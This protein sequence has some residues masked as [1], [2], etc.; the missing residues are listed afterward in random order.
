MK[1]EKVREDIWRGVEGMWELDVTGPISF[2]EEEGQPVESW[3]W[4]LYVRLPAH[5]EVVLADDS[6]R[7]GLDLRSYE[8]ALRSGERR[9]HELREKAGAVC[10]EGEVEEGWIAVDVKDGRFA[11]WL[12]TLPKGGIGEPRDF[13]V[14][15][16][17]RL[18]FRATAYKR[19]GDK[20]VI[21][22]TR[23]VVTLGMNAT[24]LLPALRFVG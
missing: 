8:Q 2:W 19:E 14:N 10:R 5:E 4:D 24:V 7:S 12:C 16:S 23:G 1:M 18:A 11:M 3:R 20:F 9:L 21:Q 6:E 22:H 17:Q 13:L 15:N